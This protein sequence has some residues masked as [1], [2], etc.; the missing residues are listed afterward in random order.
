MT[1]ADYDNGMAPYIS[2]YPSGMVDRGSDI[3]PA[4]FKQDFLQRIIIEPNGIITNGAELV[5]NI[6]KVNLTVNFQNAVS[7]N[8]KLACVLVEDSVT[9]TSNQYYQSN[10]YSCL[11]YTSPSPRD[12]LLSRMPSSA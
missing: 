4:N 1:N 6:L 2:G 3:N 11:L 7:G 8:Y 5:G 10:S 12:G 9:G